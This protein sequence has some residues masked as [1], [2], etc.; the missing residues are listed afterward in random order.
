[1]SQFADGRVSKLN[2]TP[3][4]GAEKRSD[5]GNSWNSNCGPDMQ[6]AN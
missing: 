5:V 3:P 2:V 1:M 6:D 4:T